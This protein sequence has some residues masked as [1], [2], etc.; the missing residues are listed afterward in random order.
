MGFARVRMS[1]RAQREQNGSRW[2]GV[3][4]AILRNVACWRPEQR[5][6]ILIDVNSYTTLKGR[7]LWLEQTIPKAGSMQIK[8]VNVE[9]SRV[10]EA[11]T[12]QENSLKMLREKIDAEFESRTDCPFN[13][14]CPHAIFADLKGRFEGRVKFFAASYGMNTYATATFS[15]LL[16]FLRTMNALHPDDSEELRKLWAQVNPYAHARSCLD[17]VHSANRHRAKTFAYRFAEMIVF[18]DMQMRFSDVVRNLT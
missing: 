6:R 16:S 2:F 8:E 9:A 3:N 10:R 14:I 17:L 18:L 5:S 4:S 15:E 11:L 1:D 13:V 7:L 12:Y